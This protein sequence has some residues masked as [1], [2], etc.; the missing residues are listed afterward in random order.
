MNPVDPCRALHERLPDYAAGL[1]DASF[2]LRVADHLAEGCPRCAAE[3]DD[4]T[5]AFLQIGVPAELPPLPDG[6]LDKLPALAARQPQ[7]RPEDVLP[8][9]RER[10]NGLLR[11]LVVLFAIAL[12][13]AGLWGAWTQRGHHELRRAR[14]QADSQVRRV[15][16]DYR[17][18]R[19][20]SERAVSWLE[21]AMTPGA[22]SAELV[23]SAAGVAGRIV[24][25]P[26][27]PRVLISLWGV[28]ALATGD[29]LALWAERDAGPFPLAT[30]PPR[31]PEGRIGPVAI[32]LPGPLQAPVRLMVLQQAKGA[33]PESPSG[34]PL[35]IGTLT[36]PV[37]ADP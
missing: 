28:P 21:L 23:G 15:S 17:T 26:G 5:L 30:L 11:A 35:L 2:G 32:D 29:E 12:G 37:T 20:R 14:E 22:P 7:D 8:W 36:L 4:L 31:Q 25:D 3:I 16:A 19:D 27:K 1:A 9:P 13:L 34:P 10:E 24:L 33:A 18:L 6:L